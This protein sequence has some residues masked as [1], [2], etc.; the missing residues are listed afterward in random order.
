MTTI[1]ADLFPTS[2]LALRSADPDDQARVRQFA[3]AQATAATTARNGLVKMLAAARTPAERQAAVRA[4]YQEVAAW[5]Y[6]LAARSTTRLGT[7]I[8]YSAARFRTPI[9]AA[10]TNFDRIGPVGRL[11]DGAKWDAASR[12]YRGG[13]ATPAYDAMVTYGKAAAMRFAADGIEGDVL[14]NWVD[15]PDGRRVAGNRIIRGEAAR[16][17]GEELAAR[18]AARGLDASQME[19]GGEPMYTATPAPADSD[20]IFAA[21][22]ETLADPDIT[23]G[24]FATAR[25]LLFQ[26]PQTKKGS[27]AVNRTF[28]VAA[29]AAL[30]G[31]SA[32]A[33][34]AD[35]DLRC[36]VLGQDTAASAYLNHH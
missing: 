3:N 15:L 30:L 5:R 21:A 6:E 8:A 26:A 25:Y 23:P 24:A 20:T 1:T 32:P 14:Q 7:G 11:R 2:P 9:T 35:I 17:I 10:T 36:Y 29:G 31:R 16:A 12:T 4:T 13:T 27:D 33:L 34:P 18:I 19:T 28:T 22:L